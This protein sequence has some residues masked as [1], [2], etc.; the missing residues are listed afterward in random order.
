LYHWRKT[1]TGVVEPGSS[2]GAERNENPKGMGGGG[3]EIESDRRTE[4]R[5]KAMVVLFFW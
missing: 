3:R 1:I 4:L 5:T 2:K